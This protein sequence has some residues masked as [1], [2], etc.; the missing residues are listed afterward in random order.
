MMILDLGFGFWPTWRMISMPLLLLYITLP[1][2]GLGLAVSSISVKYRDFRP[3]LTIVL[4]AGF[5]ATPIFYP[6]ELVPTRI[7][8][9]YQLNPMY[10]G[11]AFSPLDHARPII[12]DHAVAVCLDRAERGGHR[13]RLLCVRHLRAGRGR[14]SVT[15]SSFGSRASAS[16]ISCRKSTRR[17][18]S[19]AP[20]LKRRLK[21]FFPSLLGADET[22]FFWAL[23]DV[24]FEVKRGEV[25]GV[26]GENGSGKSTLLKI[27][28][29]VTP[30]TEGYAEIRGRVG[31]L[32]EV[33]TGFHPDLTGPRKHLLQRLAAGH[34]HSR[35]PLQAST[36]SSSSPESANS[37]MCRSSAIQ[38]ACMF[39][40]PIRSRRC[41]N[42]RSDSRRGSRG[43]RRGV[44]R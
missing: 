38:A 34:P 2:L 7:L 19:R 8:P 11:V 15:T 43:R 26:V 13:F 12:G 9:F 33:G 30:P 24:S 21:E 41:C 5:Y 31:S 39:A 18:Y 25:L 37:S 14:C 16:G 17:D 3:L 27:L 1:A 4:Q 6:A 28:S 32:L 36:R 22:D 20:T 10:W 29:G 44:P 23:R 35:N 42:R 40:S